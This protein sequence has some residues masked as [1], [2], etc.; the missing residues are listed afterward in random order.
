MIV[1]WESLAGFLDGSGALK[2]F[3]AL[4]VT[5]TYFLEVMVLSGYA[6]ISIH[7]SRIILPILIGNLDSEKKA[8]LKENPHATS[9]D[10]AAFTLAKLCATASLIFCFVHGINFQSNPYFYLSLLCLQLPVVAAGY[11]SYILIPK[12][13][14]ERYFCISFDVLVVRSFLRNQVVLVACA[15]IGLKYPEFFSLMLLDIVNISPVIMDIIESIK[16][17][18]SSLAWILYLFIV[19]NVIYASWGMVYFSEQM[20]IPSLVANNDTDITERRLGRVVKKSIGVAALVTENVECKTIYDCTLFM[21]Y[22]GLSEGGNAK[23]F[24]QPNVPG[25]E[26]YLPRIAFDS[27][28]FIWVG[29]V[30]MNVITGLMVD[31]FSATREEKAER[32]SIWADECFICGLKRD[33][34]EDKGLSVGFEIHLSK[35]HDVWM[36]VYYLAYLKRKNPTKLSGIESFVKQQVDEVGLEWLPSDTCFAIQDEKEGNGIGVGVVAEREATN[37]DKSSLGAVAKLD[38]KVENMAASLVALEDMMASILEK[39]D[40]KA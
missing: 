28:F 18:S 7:Q 10:P 23:A 16:S 12:N 21:F 35:D 29:I 38:A 3:D 13:G 37:D 14:F 26:T 17:S 19:T 15:L 1:P 6:A 32:A 34:Y 5:L 30:L 11:R 20:L 33:G 39:L 31:T 27:A 24:I 2:M 36:Y 9:K 22:Q 40:A 8:R 4:S 25:L